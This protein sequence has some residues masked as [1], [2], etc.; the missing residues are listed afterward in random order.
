ME[1]KCLREL[2][3]RLQDRHGDCA[4]AVPKKAAGDAPDVML[5]MMLLQLAKFAQK[6][7]QEQHINLNINQVLVMYLDTKDSVRLHLLM[8]H[9]SVSSHTGHS[10]KACS[11]VRGRGHGTKE[12]PKVRSRPAHGMQARE[13]WSI[14]GEVHMRPGHHWLCEFGDAGDGTSCEKEFKLANRRSEDYKGTRFYN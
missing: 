7:A 6:P 9:K 3:K 12:L 2:R 11:L 10:C 1:L 5:A 8:C 4:Q 14:E 13:L